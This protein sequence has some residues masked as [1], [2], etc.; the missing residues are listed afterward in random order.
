MTV[1]CLSVF[2]GSASGSF[3]ENGGKIAGICEIQTLTDLSHIER[4]VFQKKTGSFK[5][6]FSD[7]MLDRLAGFFFETGCQIVWRV[8]ADPG[9]DFHGKLFTQMLLDVS[10]TTLDRKRKFWGFPDLMDSG[11]EIPEHVLVDILDLVNIR[12]VFYG[13]MS[14]R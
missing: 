10:L 11:D 7:V 4:T 12:T 3:F 8:A 1:F 6:L 5:L 13:Q 14:N 9:K 2:G